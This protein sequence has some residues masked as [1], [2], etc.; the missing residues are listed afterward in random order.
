MKIKNALAFAVLAI[1]KFVPHALDFLMMDIKNI[2]MIIPTDEEIKIINN[3]LSK[4]CCVAEQ[5]FD[6]LKQYVELL[7]IENE[8]HNKE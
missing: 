3:Y 5:Q 1:R 2:Q 8:K 6:K 4:D 7:L